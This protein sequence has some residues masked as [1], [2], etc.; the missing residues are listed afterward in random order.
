MNSKISLNKK[1]NTS[2]IPK[3]KL[4][5]QN[6]L[7]ITTCTSKEGYSNSQSEE[8]LKSKMITLI[9]LKL[10]LIAL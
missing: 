9:E 4:L 7:N 3:N 10:L 2:H 1:I 5:A 6:L 8:A